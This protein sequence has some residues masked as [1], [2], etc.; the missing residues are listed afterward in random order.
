MIYLDYP[1]FLSEHCTDFC[2]SLGENLLQ[3]RNILVS[4]HPVGTQLPKLSESEG[5][6]LM[7]C[8]PPKVPEKFDSFA[9]FYGIQSTVNLWFK[10]MQP[11][12]ILPRKAARAILFITKENLA[13][14]EIVAKI[15]KAN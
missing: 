4:A 3:L 5:F 6:T 11:I 1:D 14:T 2:D 13:I 9:R 8:F 7:G 15:G 10:E 12:D